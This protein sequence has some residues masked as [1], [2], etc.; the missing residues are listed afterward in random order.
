MERA[1]AEFAIRELLLQIRDRLD[2]AANIARASHACANASNIDKAVEVALD[3]EQPCYEAG[4]LL[5]AA[6]LIKRISS[7]RN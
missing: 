4:R 5:D 1:P 2:N 3:I 6:R 7:H